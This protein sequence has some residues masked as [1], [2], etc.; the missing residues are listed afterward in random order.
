LA[1]AEQQYTGCQRMLDYY[2]RIAEMVT[3]EHGAPPAQVWATVVRAIVDDRGNGELG[4]E[5]VALAGVFAAAVTELTAVRP[6][7]P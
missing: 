3:R 7:A 1:R 2:L 5:L 4:E 6:V